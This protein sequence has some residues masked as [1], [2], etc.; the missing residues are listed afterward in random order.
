MLS[1]MTSAFLGSLHRCLF[2]LSFPFVQPRSSLTYFPR[3]TL[4]LNTGLLR[5][6]AGLLPV[7]DLHL[8]NASLTMDLPS[9]DQ[10]QRDAGVAAAA[11]AAVAKAHAE[12]SSVKTQGA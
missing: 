5:V 4:K 1:V 3:Q 8:R 12:A 9:A 11:A 10:I 7:A 2:H 6:A